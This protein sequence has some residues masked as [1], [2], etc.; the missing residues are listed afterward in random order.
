MIPTGPV[1]DTSQS[2]SDAAQALA[3]LRFYLDAGADAAIED[4]PIS[5]FG[6]AGAR[7]LIVS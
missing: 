3:L 7:A 5:R 2:I 6:L 4:T 1:S